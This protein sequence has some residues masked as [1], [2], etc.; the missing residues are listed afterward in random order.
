MPSGLRREW[1]A[2]TAALDGGG[3]VL[4]LRSQCSLQPRLAYFGL[5]ALFDST[6]R[7]E[8][9]PAIFD[10]SLWHRLACIGVSALFA[11]G[12]R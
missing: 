2:L 7:R 12:G 1:G 5:S 3:D 8:P 6:A 10:I 9:R 4:G 11:T